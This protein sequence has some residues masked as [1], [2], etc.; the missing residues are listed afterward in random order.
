MSVGQGLGQASQGK[1]KNNMKIQNARKFFLKLFHDLYLTLL[2][3][4]LRTEQQSVSVIFRWI[5]RQSTQ[6]YRP[7]NFKQ[8]SLLR[9]FDKL[10]DKISRQK[11]K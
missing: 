2:A 10:P 6:S 1:V 8:S 9:L 5:F 11:T 3:C 4:K 7:E